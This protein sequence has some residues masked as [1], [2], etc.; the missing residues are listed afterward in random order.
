MLYI[1]TFIWHDAPMVEINVA[2]RKQICQ[3][4]GSEKV[5]FV[6]CFISAFVKPETQLIAQ[7]A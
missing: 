7:K 6:S 3:K 1:C 5:E 2:L 4:I